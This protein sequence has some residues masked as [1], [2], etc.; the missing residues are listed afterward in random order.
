LTNITGTEILLY[1]GCQLVSYL[2]ELKFV[3]SVG[4]ICNF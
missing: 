4:G 3:S 1:V 2:K